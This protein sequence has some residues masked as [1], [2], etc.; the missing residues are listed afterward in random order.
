MN[1][2]IEVTENILEYLDKKVQSGFY[3]SRSEAV[4][5][6]IRDMIQRDLKELMESKGI[7]LENLDTLRGEVA[8]ELVKKKFGRRHSD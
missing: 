6:A 3:K 5:E 4:R 7:T 2:S 8:D 1:I